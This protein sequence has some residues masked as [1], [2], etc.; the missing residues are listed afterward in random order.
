MTRYPSDQGIQPGWED[1]EFYLCSEVDELLARRAPD[2]LLEAQVRR[3]REALESMVYQFGYDDGK[4][5]F[6]CGGLSALEEAFETLGWGVK[7][8]IPKGLLCDEPDCK[9]R[10]TCGTPTP[11]GY[12]SVCGEHYHAALAEEAKAGEKKP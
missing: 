7:H 6:W 3:L 9:Q 8:P 1:A 2:P 12:R 4:G 11:S 10:A 5:N